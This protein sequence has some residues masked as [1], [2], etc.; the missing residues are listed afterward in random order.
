MGMD[1]FSEAVKHLQNRNHKP[2]CKHATPSLPEMHNSP[3]MRKLSWAISRGGFRKPTR[4]TIMLG[5]EECAYKRREQGKE[6]RTMKNMTL[7]QDWKSLTPLAEPLGFIFHY[8][9]ICQHYKSCPFSCILAQL[10]EETENAPG[11]QYILE[12][13]ALLQKVGM[14]FFSSQGK[15]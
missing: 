15:L 6:V 7:L 14:I 2:K 11:Y 3:N 5:T 13:S 9:L 1:G 8:F 10:P 12:V 4:W